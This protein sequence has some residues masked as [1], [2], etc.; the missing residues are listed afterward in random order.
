MVR[1]VLEHFGG[2]D[3][4]VNNGGICP[5]TPVLEMDET[6]WDTAFD[7]NVKGRFLVSQRVEESS[8]ES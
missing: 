3:I 8:C 6:E 2:I 5:N 7:T 1:R 4:V